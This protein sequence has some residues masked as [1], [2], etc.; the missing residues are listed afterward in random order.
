MKANIGHLEGA[1]GLAG[2]VKAVLVLE[3]GI[4][5]PNANFDKINPAI[6]AQLYNIQVKHESFDRSLD[7]THPIMYA[8]IRSR[9]RF[10]RAQSPGQFLVSDVY[11]SIHL[12][13]VE[14]THMLFWTMLFTSCKLTRLMVTIIAP[15]RPRRRPQAKQP[16][17]LPAAPENLYFSRTMPKAF[18]VPDHA[19]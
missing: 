11:R 7:S 4:I 18:L 6:D 2:V 19:S 10:Q 16:R 17:G 8:Y 14:R 13:S 15:A 12:V 9:P 1:S 3:N 5:P